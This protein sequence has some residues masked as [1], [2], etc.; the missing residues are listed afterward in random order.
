[1]M[2][3][4]APASRG[5]ST[6]LSAPRAAPPARPASFSHA[7]GRRARLCSRYASSVRPRGAVQPSFCTTTRASAAPASAPPRP[8]AARRTT[9][10]T[11]V[12]PAGRATP[13]DILFGFR[14]R[15]RALG[16]S[17][18]FLRESTQIFTWLQCLKIFSKEIFSTWKQTFDI[19]NRF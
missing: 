7:H 2:S 11:R 14:T 3:T 12:W 8:A 18:L 9:S 13:G 19:G 16:R 1:M 4:S 5:T 6:P 10:A 15:S 17:E